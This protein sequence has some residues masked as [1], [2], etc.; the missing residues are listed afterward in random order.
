MRNACFTLAALAI[1]LASP[2]ASAEEVVNLTLK[3]HRFTP[4]QVT[5]PAGQRFRIML[6]NQ[7]STSAEL[8]SHDMKFEKVVVGG[9]SISVFAGPLKP[10][11]YKFYD[12]FHEKTATGTV[13]A[14]PK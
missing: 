13:T 2:I 3:D 1:L 5:V 12:E 7:D 9:G 6:Q 11:T 14:V 8:E 10:G 4:N